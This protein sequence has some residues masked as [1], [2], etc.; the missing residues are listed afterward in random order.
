MKTKVSIYH[1]DVERKLSLI[2]LLKEP[3]LHQQVIA[4]LEASL[5]TGDA[6]R[7]EF[8]IDAQVGGQ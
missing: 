1:C 3:A 4:D 8:I 2:A 7:R 5:V 6:Y